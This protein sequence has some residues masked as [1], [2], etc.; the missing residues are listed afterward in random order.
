[1]PHALPRRIRAHVAATVA[2]VAL[3]GA[4]PADADAE[5]VTI[6]G[7]DSHAVA[8]CLNVADGDDDRQRNRCRARAE[9]GTVTLENVDIHFRGRNG[10]EVN[11]GEVDAISVS[12]GDGE[13]GAICVNERGDVVDGRQI[14][15]CRARARGGRV[16]FR[17]V[18][19]LVHHRNGTTTRKRRTLVALAVRPSRR[20]VVCVSRGNAAADCEAMAGGARVQMRNVDLV[21]RASKTTRSNVD[22]SVTGGDA[23]ALVT[24]GNSTTGGAAQV[25]RCSSRA[26]G[27]DVRLSDVR[28]HFYRS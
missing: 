24:C 21:D 27:G 10:L 26:D 14:S 15:V 28:L 23:S 4:V 2:L 13:A 8:D 5:T 22:L 17:K 18:E 12:G 6:L 25:N 20:Q 1:M 9:G 19:I 11:D 7:T 3:A 16:T